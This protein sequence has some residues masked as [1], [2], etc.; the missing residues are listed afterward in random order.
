M[1]PNTD[2]EEKDERSSDGQKFDKSLEHVLDVLADYGIL[3]D[4]FSTE[5]GGSIKL[6]VC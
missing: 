5:I 2:P 1:A 3:K 6:N 4:L